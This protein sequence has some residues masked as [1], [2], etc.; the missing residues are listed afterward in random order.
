MLYKSAV[1]Q[2]TT[3]QRSFQPVKPQRKMS[4][5]LFQISEAQRNFRNKVFDSVEAQ[6]NCRTAFSYQAKAQSIEISQHIVNNTIF[7]IL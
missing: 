1:Q 3:T 4:N 6:R 5:L 2:N 7:A